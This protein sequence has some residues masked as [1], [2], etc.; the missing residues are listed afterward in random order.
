MLE[1]QNFVSRNVSKPMFS[2]RPASYSAAKVQTFDFQTMLSS[3][4][5]SMA[6]FALF[7]ALGVLYI[8]QVNFTSTKGYD[9]RDLEQKKVSLEK[10]ADRLALEADELQSVRRIS[11]QLADY[12]FVDGGTATAFLSTNDTAFASR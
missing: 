2:T 4:Y 3:K 9:I 7:I 6:L 10:E 8:L 12:R 5:T 1:V 11:A